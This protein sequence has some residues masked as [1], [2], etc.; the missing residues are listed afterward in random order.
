MSKILANILVQLVLL[1]VLAGCLVVLQVLETAV[2][3]PEVIAFLAQ[4]E[5][6]MKLVFAGSFA[7]FTAADAVSLLTLLKAYKAFLA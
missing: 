2:A 3:A 5:L 4:V 6:A 7:A 1:A